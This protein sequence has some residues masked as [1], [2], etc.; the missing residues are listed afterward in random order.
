MSATTCSSTGLSYIIVPLY[1]SRPPY[2][3]AARVPKRRFSG[4]RLSPVE[5]RRWRRASAEEPFEGCHER[6]GALD[7]GHVAAVGDERQETSL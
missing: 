3:V 1:R 2:R 5:A 7:V 4:S 6:I